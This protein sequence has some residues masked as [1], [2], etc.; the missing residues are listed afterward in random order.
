LNKSAQ[1][2]YKELRTA[3]ADKTAFWLGFYPIITFRPTGLENCWKPVK[4]QKVF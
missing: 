3:K 1:D 4:K 2:F